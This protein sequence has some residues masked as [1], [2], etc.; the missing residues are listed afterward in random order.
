[1]ALFLHP[2]HKCNSSSSLIRTPL[3][4]F[5]NDAGPGLVQNDPSQPLQFGTLRGYTQ[6]T[7]SFLQSITF[8]FLPV[9]AAGCTAP[10]D[11]VSGIRLTVWR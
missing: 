1:M 7:S 2:L 11:N 4:E 6:T 3:T 10:R 9:A 5:L 8:Y